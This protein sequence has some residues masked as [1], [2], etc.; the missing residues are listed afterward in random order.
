MAYKSWI[1]VWQLFFD[2]GYFFK[3]ILKFKK[4]V[5]KELKGLSYQPFSLSFNSFDFNTCKNCQSIYMLFA[6]KSW[7]T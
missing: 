1:L 3:N 4:M 6:T 5:A 2:A 7:K